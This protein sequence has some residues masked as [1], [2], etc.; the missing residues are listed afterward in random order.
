MRVLFISYQYPPYSTSGISTH[1]YNLAKALGHLDC[2]VHVVAC[3][4]GDIDNVEG[5]VHVHF[6]K[7]FSM[8]VTRDIFFS[9]SSTK[10]IDK[11]CEE[12]SIDVVHGHSP[13]CFGYGFLRAN[14]LPY[15]LTIHG[16][17]IGEILAYA[18]LPPSCVRPSAIYDACI[19]QPSYMFFTQLEYKYADKIIAVSKH[20]AQ[21]AIRYYHLPKNKV[22]V[23]YNGINVPNAPHKKYCAN[24]VILSVGRMFWR[25]GFKYLLDALPIIL[26][27]YPDTKLH[28]VGEGPYKKYLEDYAKKLKLQKSVQFLGRVST[29]KLRSLYAEASVY[30]QPSTYEPFCITILEAMSFGAPVVASRIGGIPE[31]V[32]DKVNGLLFEPKNSAQM[33][34]AVM[35]IFSDKQYALKLR[36]NGK[37]MLLRHFTWEKISQKTIE[38][39][40]RILA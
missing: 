10:K 12:Y 30:V 22:S 8:P 19:V 16:T 26:R 9:I 27:R 7:P 13:S 25:K 29:E 11:L 1:I 37:D 34:E 38:L 21:E 32:K 36:K 28:L 40:D 17:S 14:R 2:E 39:Y 6:F 18:Q 33:A 23:I 5:N 20:T 15:I 31:I 35:T 24:R 3:G 4:P